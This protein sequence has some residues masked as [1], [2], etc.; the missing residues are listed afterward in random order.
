MNVFTSRVIYVLYEKDFPFSDFAIATVLL[1]FLI[2]IT[3][4]CF[5]NEI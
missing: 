2:F 5:L 1:I 4:Y 3:I